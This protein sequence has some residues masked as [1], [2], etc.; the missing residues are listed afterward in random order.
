MKVAP[1]SVSQGA[2]KRRAIPSPK[3]STRLSRAMASRMRPRS[4]APA[5]APAARAGKGVSGP[6]MEREGPV[7][8]HLPAVARGVARV[9]QVEQLGRHAAPPRRHQEARDRVGAAGAL[10]VDGPAEAQDLL[11]RLLVD[12][13]RR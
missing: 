6:L 12:P 13:L 1:G 9:A 8:H 10:R 7:T 4:S 2:S 5:T 3:A 11:R